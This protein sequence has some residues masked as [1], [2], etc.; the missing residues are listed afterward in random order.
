MQRYVSVL[1]LSFIINLSF[2][3]NHKTPDWLQDLP[4]NT[5]EYIYAIGFSDPK[6]NDSILAKNLA[7]NRALSIAV[8]ANQSQVSYASDFYEAKSEEHRWYVTKESFEEFGRIKASAYVNNNYEIVRTEK[9]SNEEL[10]ILLKFFPSQDKNLEHNF[11]TE[12]EYYSQ[13]FELSNTRALEHFRNIILNTCWTNLTTKDSLKTYYEISNYNN[14]INIKESYGSLEI[15]A[16]RFH[17]NYK[18]SLANKIDFKD[19]GS[20]SPLQKGLWQAYLDS[21]IQSIFH[22]TKNHSSKIGTI[23]D[24]FKRHKNTPGTKGQKTESLTRNT[25]KNILNFELGGIEIYNNYLYNR[26]YLQNKRIAYTNV[27]SLQ[28]NNEKNNNS[29]DKKNKECFLKRWFKKKS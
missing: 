12:L 5:N 16:P 29:K 20:Y 26:V 10:I 21:Y 14:Y 23:Q 25:L 22:I 17:Y 7:L 15:E 6:M 1:I 19:F 9:N 11:Y 8:M 2:A 13:V 3:Q 18:A 28:I 24:E 4:Y 27:T